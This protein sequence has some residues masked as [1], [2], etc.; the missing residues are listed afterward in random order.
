MHKGLP[1]TWHLDRQSMD[2]YKVFLQGQN[3]GWSCERCSSAA[4]PIAL[5]NKVVASGILP[6]Q[7]RQQMPQQSLPVCAPVITL[8]RALVED[9]TP[10][11]EDMGHSWHLAPKARSSDSMTNSLPAA[12]PV[13][14]RGTQSCHEQEPSLIRADHSQI[15]PV[16]ISQTGTYW[17]PWTSP[18]ARAWRLGR[19]FGQVSLGYKA[20][21]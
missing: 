5:N 8:R 4:R 10:P 13:V 7:A 1:E 3:I 6:H 21:L 9:S 17:L 12:S 19:E 18:E 15:L 11:Q 2:V 16:Q 14:C 20:E